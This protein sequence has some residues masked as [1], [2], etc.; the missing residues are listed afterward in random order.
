MGYLGGEMISENKKRKKKIRN[1]IKCKRKEERKKGR[2][3]KREKMKIGRGGERG[4]WGWNR[5]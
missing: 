5:E 4:E 2:R 1:E 3:E